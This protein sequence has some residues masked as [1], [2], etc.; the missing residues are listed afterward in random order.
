MDPAVRSD[1]ALASALSGQGCQ[2]SSLGP[3]K[4]KSV[5]LPS[6]GYA[7]AAANTQ[8]RACSVDWD[9][10]KCSG[11]QIVGSRSMKVTCDLGSFGEQLD[12]KLVAEL[13][14]VTDAADRCCEYSISYSFS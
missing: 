12:F 1:L 8:P 6:G 13:A 11:L 2:E 5:W 7:L 4:T 14:P 3:L 9:F 10:S